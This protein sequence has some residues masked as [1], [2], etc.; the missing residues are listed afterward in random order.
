MKGYCT[1]RIAGWDTHGLPVELEVE[2]ALGFSGKRQ[3]EEF[4]IAEFNAKCRESVFRYVQEWEE[5]TDFM[6]EALEEQDSSD[7]A[8]FL[9]RERRLFLWWD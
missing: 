3:I 1:P 8:A 2:R 6:E 5:M 7:L 4:G 9:A